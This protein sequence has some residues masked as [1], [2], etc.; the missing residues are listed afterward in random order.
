MRVRILSLGESDF[1]NDS[2]NGSFAMGGLTRYDSGCAVCGT[3]RC[4]GQS[5]CE[6]PVLPGACDGPRGMFCDEVWLAEEHGT[7]KIAL[8]RVHL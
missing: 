8:L 1:A 6:K 2:G 4:G 7:G 5:G 3:R